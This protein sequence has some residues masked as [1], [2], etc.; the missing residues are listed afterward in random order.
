VRE[1]WRWTLRGVA[2]LALAAGGVLL[3]MHPTVSYQP[4]FFP[5]ADQAIPPNLRVPF[6][7]ISPFSQLTG[8]R[9]VA[10]DSPPPNAIGSPLLPAAEVAALQAVSAA[11][12]AATN[13]REHIVEALGIGAILLVGLS[14]LPRRREPATKRMLE[15]S[16]V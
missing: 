8:A 15:A 13:G 12:S 10:P 6:L 3:A 5:S 4:P 7:C 9:Q 14:F 16:P 1:W 2:A 11:C